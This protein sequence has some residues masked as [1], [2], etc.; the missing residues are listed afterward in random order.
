MGHVQDRWYKTVKGAETGKVTRVKTELYGNGMR[1]K[2]RYFDPDGKEV[3]RSFPDRAKRQ[4]DEFLHK[5]ENEK[6]EGSY[7]DPHGDKVKFRDYAEQWL[8]G[9]SL[10]STTRVNVPSRLKT[11]HTRSL[12]TSN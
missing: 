7:L 12:G 11:R 8:S 6:R 4:A 5:V 3:S 9:Q 10:K 2:V 1:Y